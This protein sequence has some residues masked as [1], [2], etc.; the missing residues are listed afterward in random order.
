[1]VPIF[2]KFGP[3]LTCYMVTRLMCESNMNFQSEPSYCYSAG[4]KFWLLSARKNWTA[5]LDEIDRIPP[6]FSSFDVHF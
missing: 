3:K 5:M 1:M 6:K 4:N 2:P